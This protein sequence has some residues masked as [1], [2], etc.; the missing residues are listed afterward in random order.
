MQHK[1]K[2]INHSSYKSCSATPVSYDPV[3]LSTHPPGGPQRSPQHRLAHC[4]RAPVPHETGIALCQH[5]TPWPPQHLQTRHT[6]KIDLSASS[7]PMYVS[8]ESLDQEFLVWGP[9]HPLENIEDPKELFYLCSNYYQYLLLDVK[10]L[11]ILNLTIIMS[12]TEC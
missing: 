10:T 2:V 8:T 7:E 5:K 11:N 4:P 1:H 6:D 3:G 9:L 12:V